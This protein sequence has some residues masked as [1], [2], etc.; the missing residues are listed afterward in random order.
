MAGGKKGPKSKPATGGTNT[1]A[2]QKEEL[3][4]PPVVVGISLG[5]SYASISVEGQPE[6]I[7]NENGERQIACAVSFNGQEVYVGNQARPQ[8]VKNSQNTITNFRNLLGKKFS[9]L[10]PP[11]RTTSAT[12]IAGPNDV[13]AYNVTYIPAPPSSATPAPASGVATPKGPISKKGTPAAS[14]KPTPMATPRPSS[15]QPTEK[16]ITVPEVTTMFLD[17]L[18]GSA[19]DFLGKDIDGA[20][21]TCP[22]WFDDEQKT[23]LKQAAAEAG[24]PI[25]G[26]ADEAAAVVLAYEE[27]E[28]GV[29]R[30]APDRISL[31]V[32]MGAS[33]TTVTCLSVK[34]GLVYPLA[35]VY[36]SDVGGNDVD[37]ILISHFAKEFTKKNKVPLNFP[38]TTP[39][40]ARAEAKL[41]LEVEHT[42]RTFSAGRNTAPCSVESLKEGYDLHS[43]LTLMRLEMLIRP[44]YTKLDAK[45]KECLDKAGVDPVFVDEVLLAGASAAL[46]K[47]KEHIL[48]EVFGVLDDDEEEEEAP[49]ATKRPR[50]EIRNSIP[51]YEVQSLGA[52]VHAR[53]LASL[54]ADAKPAFEENSA[55]TRARATE[56]PIGLKLFQA[57]GSTP[58]IPIVYAHTP[59]PARRIV[60]FDVDAAT[61]KKVGF[62]VWEGEDVVEARR[63]GELVDEAAEREKEKAKAEK[64]EEDED[65][66]EEEPIVRSR[67]HKETTR[68]GAL[69][70][71]LDTSGPSKVLVRIVVDADGGVEIK[72]WEETS[73]DKGKTL[74]IPA[75]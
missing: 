58:W 43:S 75:P 13:P 71:D 36:A 56:K 45:I 21:I 24:L 26:F 18:R 73:E 51:P 42:K 44:V 66:D 59:I 48:A 62:E 35:S 55:L 9:S 11:S 50:V 67:A 15:P 52:V 57:D 17:S 47:L 34:A 29:T 37:T 65:E 33:H 74:S 14:I 38:A 70:L 61:V 63:G 39:E 28:R 40:D 72:L 7:A 25:I 54:P 49:S 46:A 1:P 4:G 22:S 32:D 16:T 53:I 12:V 2:L 6:C 30:A 60:R 23:A 27:R 19:H 64:D 10:T 68:L 41:R 3:K 5:D 31:V 69:E 8:L 20:V